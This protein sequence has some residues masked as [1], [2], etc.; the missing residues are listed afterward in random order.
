M[1]PSDPKVLE[2]LEQ[3]VMDRTFTCGEVKLELKSPLS[4]EYP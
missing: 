3:L 1:L 4:N 2:A